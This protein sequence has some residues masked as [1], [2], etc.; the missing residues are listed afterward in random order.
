[1]SVDMISS[2]VLGKRNYNEET[3]VSHYPIIHNEDKT[4][5]EFTLS[6]VKIQYDQ[7]Y[8]QVFP[9]E[10]ALSFFSEL[11]EKI[12]NLLQSKVRVRDESTLK[13]MITLTQSDGN[14][15]HAF[16]KLACKP[17][18]FKQFEGDAN[19]LKVVCNGIF[20]NKSTIT[21][22]WAC[23]PYEEEDDDI[24]VII[25]DEE[26]KKRFED[27]MNAE[28]TDMTLVHENSGQLVQLLN[29][30]KDMTVKDQHYEVSRMEKYMKEYY[31]TKERLF[32]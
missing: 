4:T 6:D 12:F 32:E 3:K 2:I 28:L 5:L 26:G 21:I 24:I 16:I 14:H 30:I 7:C 1:M 9:N 23:E 25:P 13:R 8:V 27:E 22:D 10:L 29:K 15:E 20:I 17:E 18:N 19:A 11:Q 31:D